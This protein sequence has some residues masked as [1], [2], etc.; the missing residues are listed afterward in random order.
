MT[1]LRLPAPHF[2]V[3]HGQRSMLVPVRWWLLETVLTILICILLVMI[4]FLVV[5]LIV[6]PRAVVRRLKSLFGRLTS[7]VHQAH[8]PRQQG[9]R[10]AHPSREGT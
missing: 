10:S 7:R 3:A 1:G 6:A 2:I 4:E 8:E 9:Q 5:A